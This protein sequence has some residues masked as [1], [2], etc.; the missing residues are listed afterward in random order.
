MSSK[1]GPFAGRCTTAG[2][3]AEN[4]SKTP[5][6]RP[7]VGIAA[8][9]AWRRNHRRVA[10][11]GRRRMHLRIDARGR[12]QYAVRPRQFVAERLAG[13]PGCG[14]LRGH[15]AI[16]GH[17]WHR[18]AFAGARW[19]WRGGLRR[20]RRGR[21]RRLGTGRAGCHRQQEGKKER[22]FRSHR[23][24]TASQRRGSARACRNL[25]ICDSGSA[26]NAPSAAWGGVRPG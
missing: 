22:A 9:A 16:S 19:R 1:P 26:R 3:C 6:F 4:P 5:L 21:W 25:R 17:G 8:G 15:G 2:P 24:K 13:F 10:G 23:E 14:A 20:R 18:R 11:I 7:D 12:T